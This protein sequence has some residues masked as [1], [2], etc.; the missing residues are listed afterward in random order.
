MKLKTQ[1][2][3]LLFTLICSVAVI[4][5]DHIDHP[6]GSP[7]KSTQYEGH[8][9]LKKIYSI[10]ANPEKG[11]YWPYYLGTPKTIKENVAM[12]VEPNNDARPGGPFE[13]H[14]YWAGVK[15]EQ[16]LIDYGNKLETFVLV[17]V[18]PR[19]KLENGSNLYVHA[20]T[21]A[22]IENK[23]DFLKRVD[24]QLLAMVEDAKSK[25][26][27]NNFQIPDKFMLW[28][29][30]AAAD[31]VTRMAII[32]PETIQCVVAGGLGGF[33]ILPIKTLEGNPLT[34]PVGI[35]DFE[36]LFNKPFNA[37]AFKSIPMQFFQGGADENDSVAEVEELLDEE[38]FSSDSYSYSQCILIN[39]FFGTIPVDRVSK[40]TE[41][42]RNFGMEIFQYV[43]VPEIDHRTEP[44]EDQVLEF[45]K[46]YGMTK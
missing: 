42:Y 39:H 36:Q 18:F 43:M 13:T 45:L 29:F 31:F 46:T 5:Q 34:Y 11:F 14:D 2:L 1:Y 41:I 26:R 25:I 19:P 44:F 10:P 32:N 6:V 3:S 23:T 27:D 20:L 33:P 16:A 4:A 28:G 15:C 12:L 21:R 38:N 35:S 9:E 30:S 17:P 22:V 7:A 24:L 37:K 8:L 40:V